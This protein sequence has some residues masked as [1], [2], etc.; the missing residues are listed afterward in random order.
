MICWIFAEVKGRITVL[1][2][3]DEEKAPMVFWGVGGKF[4]Q[5]NNEANPGWFG[6]IE[7]EILPSYIGIITNHIKDPY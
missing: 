3:A 5:L 1:K 7:D 6:Y 2:A 4:S